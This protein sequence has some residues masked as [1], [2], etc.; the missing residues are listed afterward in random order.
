M[1]CV[2]N[3]GCFSA[4]VP[5]EIFPAEMSGEHIIEWEWL[6]IKRILTIDG[7][8]G[9]DLT[10]PNI[11]NEYSTFNLTIKAPNGKYYDNE[12]ELTDEQTTLQITIK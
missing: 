6:G 8:E 7:V 5:I 10:L 3:I 9:E 11:F 12:G 2:N 1:A 4:C